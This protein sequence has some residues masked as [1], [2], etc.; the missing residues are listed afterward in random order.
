MHDVALAAGVSV[1]TVSRVLN[2]HPNVSRKTRERVKALIGQSGFRP[3]AIAR[4]LVHGR[5]GQICF[6]LSNREIVHSFHSRV[7]KGAEDYCRQSH[8]QVVFATVSYGPDDDLPS[9]ELPRIIREHGSID[10]ILL[11]GINYPNLRRYMEKLGLPYV[12]FGNNLLTGSLAYPVRHAVCFDEQGGAREAVKLLI[13][14]GHR[15]I[16]WVG[17]LS[18]AWYRRRY[19]GYRVAMQSKRLA[20]SLVD[21]SDEQNDEELGRRALPIL[22]RRFPKTSAILAQDDEA[23]C[24]LLDGMRKLGIR[25]PQDLSLVGYD[26]IAEIRYVTPLLTTVRVPKE[27]VGWA[28]AD[29]LFRSIAA[30]NI[31]PAPLPLPTEL[32]IR[33]SCG[34]TRPTTRL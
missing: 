22:L 11:A 4:R 24:G 10:G 6:L 3:N 17:N 27:K 1:A 31:L 7:L 18:K 34:R 25:V 26:D 12:I 21:L 29:L 16:A 5:S 8:N 28:M 2:Q 32:V 14:L 23:A 15:R 30:A 13:E 20:L 33:E 19:E 9:I